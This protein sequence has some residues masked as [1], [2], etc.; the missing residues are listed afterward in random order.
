MR[1]REW[2]LMAAT[3][4]MWRAIRASWRTRGSS[5]APAW[6]ALI[7]LSVLLAVLTG[8]GAASAADPKIKGEVKV[9]TV[10][11]YARLVFRMAEEVDA[12]VR[13]NGAIMI[14][15]F[16]KP[17][18][19]SVDK[20]N[21][22]APEYISAA[23]R[24]PDGTAVRVALAQP[25]GRGLRMR[26]EPLAAEDIAPVTIHDYAWVG[27]DAHVLKGVTIGAGAIVASGSVVA[28]DVP[29]GAI[30]MGVPARVIRHRA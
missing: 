15:S 11:G 13:V 25:L 20:L 26:G 29:D 21:S 1:R 5:R 14:I 23:R 10:G 18:D 27:R 6:R 2:V 7:R 28:T 30:A 24:D 17:V 12:N 4:I 19:I 3:S 16:K 9:S 8:V 22:D